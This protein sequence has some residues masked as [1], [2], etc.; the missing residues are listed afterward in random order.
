MKSSG[1]PKRPVLEHFGLTE[2]EYVRATHEAKRI[3]L[4]EMS[5]STATALMIISV[6]V[7]V[8]SCLLGRLLYPKYGFLFY[9]L[10]INPFT[11]P[12]LWA[13]LDVIFGGWFDK[14]RL[15]G[16]QPILEQIDRYEQAAAEYEQALAAYQREHEDHWKSLK[17]VKLEKELA[18]LYRDLGYDVRLT[19][20]TGDKGVD[21]RIR[22]HGCTIIVQCKG[23]SKPVGVAAARDLYGTL[24]HQRA[25][26]AVLACPVG[27]TQGVRSFAKGKPIQLLSAS[28]LVAMAE[29]IQ[30]ATPQAPC[31]SNEDKN[32]VCLHG[33]SHT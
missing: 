12:F 4:R 33:T 29:R 6:L 26:R 11:L 2:N 3:H 7:P 32:R 24:I 1:K 14:R 21:L 17:G 30:G 15:R 23:Y 31:D 13:I 20:A 18:T 27:F 22:R 19:E 8:M 9:G 25:D 16:L 28:E 10:A 5:D